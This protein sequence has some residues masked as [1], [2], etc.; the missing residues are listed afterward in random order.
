MARKCSALCRVFSSA[1]P[2]LRP[3]AAAMLLMDMHD[4]GRSAHVAAFVHVYVYDHER[5]GSLF[6]ASKGMGEGMG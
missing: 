5:S 4:R 1:P 2:L 6:T 3:S